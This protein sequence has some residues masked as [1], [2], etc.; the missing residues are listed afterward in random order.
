MRDFFKVILFLFIVFIFLIGPSGERQQYFLDGSY[1][2]EEK[3]ISPTPIPQKEPVIYTKKQIQYEGKPQVLHILEVDISNPQVKI[4]P[5]LST[6]RIFGFEYLSDINKRYNA[7]AT[8]NAGFNYPYGQPS[9]LFIQDGRIVSSSKGYGRILLIGEKKAW[10]ST[11]PLKVWV[12]DEDYKL[13]VDSV[14]P[15]P[16][17]KGILIYTPEYGA[18]NRIDTEHTV[19]VVR[20]NIVESSQIASGETQIPDDGFLIADLRVENSP[21]LNFYVGQ[22]VEISIESPIEEGDQGVEM[23]YQDTEVKLSLK[24]EHGYQCSGS[25]VENGKNVSKD[26][27]EWAGNLRIPT[28]KTAVGLKDENTLVFLVVDGRQPEYSE[29][30]TGSQ[31]AD[32]LISLG[33]TEAAILDGGASSE[34]IY[35]GEIANRPSTGKE[36]L[37]ATAF[38]VIITQ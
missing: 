19:T 30:V 26:L 13:P 6:D 15:Y 4:L 24:I 32:I 29:G 17:Q 8:I 36:R 12:G 31:L 5:V 14:N 34:L 27:D 22:N 11:P 10:F 20:N 37:L 1:L 3:S 18:T 21:L 7:K 16:K 33:V 9:G 2:C 35:N 38:V 25:L 23:E 28:P